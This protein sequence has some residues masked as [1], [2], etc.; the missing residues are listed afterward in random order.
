MK[1]LKAALA[2]ASLSWAC[3][4][5]AVTTVV[6]GSIQRLGGNAVGNS[7]FDGFTSTNVNYIPFSVGSMMSVEIDV[8]SYERSS[9][10]PFAEIDINGDGLIAYFDPTIYL[11]RADGT[12]GIEDFTGQSNE[13]SFDTFGD[14]SI[15]FLDPYLRLA[16]GVLTAGNYLIAIGSDDL[17][18]EQA[19]AGI[20]P[21]S[22]GPI[23]PG[24]TVA[25]F[26]AYRVTISVVPEPAHAVL[27]GAGL[28]GMLA[29]RRR[30]QQQSIAA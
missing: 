2:I 16:S 12:L 30:A 4:A 8:R 18:L 6:D 19:I 14:G 28:A 17:S 3:S 10:A 7:I 23:G 15:S 20:N 22:L 26:G 29:W 9:T 13:F 5:S 27:F 25:A 1:H 11:F 21:F 24:D